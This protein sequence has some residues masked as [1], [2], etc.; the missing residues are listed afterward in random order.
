MEDERRRFGAPPDSAAVAAEIAR[1]RLIAGAMAFGIVAA[2]AAL[3]A[4]ATFGELDVQPAAEGGA[5]PVA[6][7][8]VLVAAVL[9]V[10][11]P[12]VE[13]FLS[14]SGGAGTPPLQRYRTAKV[15]SL[16]LRESVGLLGLVV[17]LLGVSPTW[18]YALGAA[19]LLAIAL[20]WP[21]EADLA[22]TPAA[23]VGPE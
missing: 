21:R 15:V 4:A 5:R 6:G 12:F 13:R 10:A 14:T 20:A 1:L 11:A 8:L 23:P 7:L 3:W 17:G 22:S 18:G 16:A 9:L 2:M 19:S